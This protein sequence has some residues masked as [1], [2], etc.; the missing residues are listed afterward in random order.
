MGHGWFNVELN[1][2]VGPG[3][4]PLLN[5]RFDTWT[6]AYADMYETILRDGERRNV[7]LGWPYQVLRDIFDQAKHH[8]A[9]V[10][11]PQFVEL[12]MWDKAIL[13]RDGQPVAH[14]DHERALYGDPMLEAGF[15]ALDLPHFGDAQAFLRGYGKAEITASER[16][17]RQLYT[18]QLTVVMVIECTYRGYLGTDHAAR[19]QRTFETMMA[20]YGYT[21]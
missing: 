1:Q 21:R 17:R 19:C 14:I 16:A 4:G 20:R 13:L 11:V 3:F 8:L 5:P 9:D 18:L 15:A 7:D 10:T 2:I 6:E 12:D